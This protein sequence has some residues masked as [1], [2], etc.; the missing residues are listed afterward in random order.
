MGAKG[1]DN[2]DFRSEESLKTKLP[3]LYKLAVQEF[4]K[5]GQEKNEFQFKKCENAFDIIEVL[6]ESSTL[7]FVLSVKGS[8]RKG[9]RVLE[10]NVSE[11][12]TDEELEE[13][14]YFWED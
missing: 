2:I 8:E 6:Y 3:K 11:A 10:S 13:L 7:D 14:G 4:L 1:L 5:L 12:L 9:Y